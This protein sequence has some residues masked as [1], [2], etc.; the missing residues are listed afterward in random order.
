MKDSCTAVPLYRCTA[1]VQRTLFVHAYMA[2][3]AYMAISFVIFLH[4][5]L[6]LFSI[7]V[8][9]LRVSYASV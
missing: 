7:T 9:I 5:L 8:C 2:V 1:S 4:I 3:A 6:V